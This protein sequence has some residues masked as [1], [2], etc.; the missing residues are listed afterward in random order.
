MDAMQWAE[1]LAGIFLASWMLNAAIAVFGM[2]EEMRHASI[3]WPAELVTLA[4]MATGGVAA[5][6]MVLVLTKF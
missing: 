2:R 4:L 5:V 6:A 3:G 1:L